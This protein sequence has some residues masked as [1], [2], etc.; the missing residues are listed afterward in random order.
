MSAL[1]PALQAY[2][3]DRLIAQRAASPNTIGAYRLTFRLLLRFAS[4]RTGKGPSKLDIAEL[5][6]PLIA[7]FLDH[8]E[9][10]RHNS[11]ATRN[12]RLDRPQARQALLPHP[13]RARAR[14]A[15]ASYLKLTRSRPTSPPSPQ[16]QTRAFIGRA[17]VVLEPLVSPS[18]P[19]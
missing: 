13:A 14:G 5:D 3:T 2:F 1:A 11:P 6:A 19:L 16:V 15:Q 10:D 8:L 17:Q 9:R 12:N 18:A 4:K 7:A